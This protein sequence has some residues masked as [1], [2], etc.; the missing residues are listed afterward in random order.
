MTVDVGAGNWARADLDLLLD[1]GSSFST[2]WGGDEDIAA[3][4]HLD[5]ASLSGG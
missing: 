2:G 1:A 3:H 4:F 5:G